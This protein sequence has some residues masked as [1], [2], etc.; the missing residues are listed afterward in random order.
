MSIDVNPF[1]DA[2]PILAVLACFA[3]SE[4]FLYGAQIARFKESDRLATITQELRKMGAII[5]EFPDALKIIP[6]P[7][8]GAKVFSHHDHRIAMALIVAAMGASGETM[9]QNIDCMDKSFP[10][11]IESFQG[12]GANIVAQE[13]K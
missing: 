3:T 9:I 13:H 10:G 7:L 11:F 5:E 6:T 8:K 4:S 2:L 12:L 1:I